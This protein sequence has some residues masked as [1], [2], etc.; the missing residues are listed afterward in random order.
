MSL[1]SFTKCACTCR[2]LLQ[3]TEIPVQASDKSIGSMRKSAKKQVTEKKKAVV[4]ETA[5]ESVA[6]ASGKRQ[7]L[8][9]RRR[10]RIRS[11]RTLAKKGSRDKRIRRL[12]K[13]HLRSRGVRKN[14]RAG[15]KRRGRR[16][17]RRRIGRR[18]QRRRHGS[19]AGG[20][21]TRSQRRHPRRYGR[22]NDVPR[23]SPDSA[24]TPGNPFALK[25]GPK[26]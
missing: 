2:V 3:R 23:Q 25:F 11:K 4:T 24:I 20:G 9:D 5:G 21:T 10:R 1:N 13:R 22:R 8:K 17:G 26:Q 7:G 16:G 14:R 15:G 19:G 12:R 6:K 18:Q